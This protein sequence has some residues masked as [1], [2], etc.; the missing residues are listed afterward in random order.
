MLK[1]A[2]KALVFKRQ[3]QIYHVII[4]LFNLITVNLDFFNITKLVKA[5]EPKNNTAIRQKSQFYS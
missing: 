4:D 1:I 3:K 5:K 2:S